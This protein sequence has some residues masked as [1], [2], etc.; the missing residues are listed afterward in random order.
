LIYRSLCFISALAVFT[1]CGVRDDAEVGDLYVVEFGLDDTTAV[2]LMV[3][4]SQADVVINNGGES[5]NLTNCGDGCYGVPVFGGSIRGSWI[6][7]VFYGDWVDSLR[8]GNYS[9][10]LKISPRNTFIDVAEAKDTTT[11]S[12]DT[13]IGKLK[14][15]Q[16]GDSVLATVLTPTGDY[17]FL[18]GTMRGSKLVL[19]TFDG[20]HLFHFSAIIIGDSI[21]NGVFKSGIHY[22][23]NWSGVRGVGELSWV[24]EQ[25]ANHEVEVVF[26]GVGVD[27]VEHWT[28]ERIRRE[29]KK[30][31]VVDVMG[32]WCPNCLDEA[33]L[34]VELRELYPDV[35][36]LSMAFERGGEGVALKRLSSFKKELGLSWDMLYGGSASKVEADSVMAFMGG[37][38][39]FP[40]TAFIPLIGPVVVHTGFS[41]PATGAHYRGELEFF[42]S[43]IEEMLVR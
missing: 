39:S 34:L 32:T 27:G 16:F 10:P 21:I 9:V 2:S 14:L 4:V 11:T 3:D 19:G 42:K 24:C 40:T 15:K 41:G 20:A 26:S 25:E 38:R 18:S 28:R 17:R 22:A 12:W 37:V 5:I 8:A 33:R 29:G 1:A 35:L 23:D 13:S 30:M 31:L 36:F 7:G 43:T 6:G